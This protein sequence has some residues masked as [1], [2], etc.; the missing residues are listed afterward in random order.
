MVKQFC[1][2]KVQNINY[3]LQLSSFR[4]KVNWKQVK[5]TYFIDNNYLTPTI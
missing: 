2:L 5:I 3:L 4:E 1:L